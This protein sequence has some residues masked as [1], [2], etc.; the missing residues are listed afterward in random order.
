M[1]SIQFTKATRKKSRLRLGVSGPA[2]SGKTTAA[3]ELAT[4]LGGRIAVIDTEFGS[5]SLYSNDYDFDVIEL[6]D[7][8]ERGYS[9]ER[10]IEAIKAAQ[11]AGYD[12]LIIDGVTPEWVGKGGCNEI[13]EKL[14]Q[15]RYKGNTWSAW[16]E[17]KPRHKL[18]IDAILSSRMDVICT[19]RSKTE[20]VQ[21]G[22]RIKKLGMKL[23]QEAGFEYEMGVIF[24]LD[25]QTHMANATKDRTKLFSGKDPFPIRREVGKK[26][27]AWLDSGAEVVM[28]P[29]EIAAKRRSDLSVKFA[30]ALNPAG[31]LG[32]TEEEHE[33]AVAASVFA[34]H[35][36]VH[37]LGA[38]E[39]KAVWFMIPSE[40]R[41]ALKKYI[42]VA[43]AKKEAA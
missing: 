20:T 34:V 32:T 3:L 35:E 8:D 10:Y 2:G 42:E 28:T 16:S 29:E 26:L 23:E 15:A 25:H 36:E 40:S 43:K 37:V 22:G 18:F 31:D 12:V 9:P 24:E 11:A 41:A 5:A 1:S 17:T 14:A 30:Q 38:D 27:R 33:A 19:V 6:D 13:N 7:T 4:G 39:Y 21:D